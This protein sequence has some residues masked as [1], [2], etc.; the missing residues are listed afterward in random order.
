MSFNIWKVNLSPNALKD[1][2]LDTNNG[3]QDKVTALSPH[4]KALRGYFNLYT[5]DFCVLPLK[6]IEVDRLEQDILNIEDEQVKAY[7]RKVISVVKANK[8]YES[9]L[10]WW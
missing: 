9:G 6:F 8:R 4:W 2:G 7:L 3:F 10:V 1:V 5:N